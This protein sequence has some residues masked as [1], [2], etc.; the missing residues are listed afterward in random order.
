MKISA[1]NLQALMALASFLGA[2]VLARMTVNINS[3][4]W[5]GG[6]A[7]ITYLR[8]LIGFL[9]TGAIVMCLYSFAG[10]SIISD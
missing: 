10:I 8:M 3:G 2:L 1:V 7:I 9:I 6:T 5:P 4:K